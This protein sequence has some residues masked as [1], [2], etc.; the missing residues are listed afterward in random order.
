MLEGRADLE[1]Q[2]QVVGAANAL[3]AFTGFSGNYWKLVSGQNAATVREKLERA[4]YGAAYRQGQAMSMAETVNL[5]NSTLG[6]LVS[7]E[8]Q[9][10]VPAGSLPVARL[11]TER[12]RA[13]LALVAE[14][15]S[16]KDV[17]DLMSISRATVSYHLNSIFTKLGAKT[18]AQAVAIAMRE[19]LLSP[20]S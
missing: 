9:A 18:R 8:S 3:S 6:S 4:G 19:A 12:E 11:L 17:G 15:H 20:V 16:N 13:V 14:G 2:A 5:I 1:I 10:A 7:A